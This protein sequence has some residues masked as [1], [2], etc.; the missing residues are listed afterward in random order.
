MANLL[1]LQA[2]ENLVS[3]VKTVLSEH[4]KNSALLKLLKDL[5]VGEKSDGDT[6]IG[7][8]SASASRMKISESHTS[9]Q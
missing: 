4:G 9:E 5:V 2:A 7:S 8:K 1:Q 6:E 3:Q